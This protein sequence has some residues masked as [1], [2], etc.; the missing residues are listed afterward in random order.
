MAMDIL[1]KLW[2]TILVRPYVF[3][4]LAAY[5]ATSLLQIGWRRML[6]LGL[7]GFLFGLGSEALSVRT[8]FPFGGYEYL[9]HATR[10]VELWLLDVPVMASLS[11]IFLTYAGYM[12]SLL[13]SAPLEGR[14]LNLRFSDVNAALQSGRALLL[15]PVFVTLLLVVI[16]RVALQGERWFLG[17]LYR[18][19]TD[20]PYFDV[21]LSNFAG[22]LLVSFLIVLTF[23]AVNRSL[24]TRRQT[25]EGLR[26]GPPC[27][28]A[29]ATQSLALPGLALYAGIL[30][31]N[32]AVTFAI[33]EFRLGLI[34]T[35]I[36]VGTLGLV[37]WRIRLRYCKPYTVGTHHPGTKLRDEFLVRADHEPMK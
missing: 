9:S 32:L 19:E 24:G 1:E 29:E 11:F 8:S 15:T 37:L 4:F 20:G 35:T 12:T 7:V 28:E 27:R 14:G 25:G 18:Y 21:P 16:D 36:A 13:V 2:G 17:R 10:D 23:Q 31:F 26:T 3:A 30:A 34:S 5:V 6:A 22:W 33:G